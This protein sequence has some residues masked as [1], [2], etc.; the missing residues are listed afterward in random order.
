MFYKFFL[1]FCFL[2]PFQFALN[3]FPGVDL[4]VVR[5]IIPL[6]FTVGLFLISK[7]KSFSFLKNKESYCLLA[8]LF[9][10]VASLGFSDNLSWSIRKLSFLLSIFPIYFVVAYF[11]KK[12]ESWRK[13]FVM[14]VAGAALLAFFA[15]IQFFLQFIFGIDSVYAFLAENIAPFFLGNSFSQ[16]VLTYPSWLVNSEG[17]TYMRAVANFPDPHML[18]YYFG[19][20]I[21]W[22]LALWST[23]QNYKKIFLIFS[24]LLIIADIM[25]FTRGSYVAIIASSLI[26]M[27][28]VSKETVKKLIFGIIIFIFLLITMPHGPVTGR[29]VSSFDLQEGSNQGRILNW[30]QATKIIVSH[31]LGVG[32]GMY[33]LAIKPE[34]SYREPIYAHNLYLDIAAELG[35]PALLIFVYFLFLIFK[36]FWQLAKKNPFFVAGIA[37]LSIFAVHSLVESP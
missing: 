7:S 31:P 4:A 16:A 10:A 22:S 27:P 28:I 17:A 6:F 36:G 8:F 33:S 19:L 29:F 37:S 21:P 12:Q 14:L 34:A 2:L 25:T 13:I 18:S 35:I 23:S 1:I 30:E 9:L 15:I 24:F 32:I 11:L 3:P 20:L 26:I 5:I